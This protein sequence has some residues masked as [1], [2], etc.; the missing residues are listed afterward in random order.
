LLVVNFDEESSLR[1]TL[2]T[3]LGLL[4][5]FILS[6]LLFSGFSDQK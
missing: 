4:S 1:K 5:T 3:I 2:V 6:A